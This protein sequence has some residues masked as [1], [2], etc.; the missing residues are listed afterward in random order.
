MA[1]L[2]KI[3][4]VLHEYEY[5]FTNSDG[6]EKYLTSSS[7]KNITLV[8]NIF[9]PFMRGSVSVANPFELFE[10][11]FQ[12]RG[13]GRD[14]FRMT[15]KTL[16]GNPSRGG[17]DSIE[18]SE[19]FIL[20]KE[21]NTG[22]MDVRSENIKSFKIISDDYLPFMDTIPYGRKYQGKV[23]DIIRDIFIELL[24]E[25]RID[26]ER[27][28]SGDFE[29]E[30][31]PPSS[32]RYVD[33]IYHLLKFFYGKDGELYVKAIIQRDSITR[34]YSM[35][36]ISRLFV[37]NSQLV[38]DVFTCADLFNE[39]AGA[40]NS[41]NPNLSDS[42]SVL[43]YSSGIKNF[44]Y[45]TPLYEWNNDF[46]INYIVHGYDPSLGVHSMRILRL[47]DIEPKWV[48]KFVN[49]FPTL[50][51]RP[52]PF[53]VKNN[54]TARKFRQYRTPYTIEDNVKMVESEIYNILTFYNL[55]CTFSNM[56]FLTRTAGKFV[57][58]VKIG[59]VEIESDQKMFGRWFITQIKHVFT[60]DSYSNFFACCKTYVGPLN[61][62]NQ[63]V[64]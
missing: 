9:N 40:G 39:R 46:F 64:N 12:L 5:V 2:I 18:F 49:F 35:Q 1:N 31:I 30:Y 27:W 14:K 7:V 24:G 47:E 19:S 44:A 10:D 36:F 53:L 33:L 17:S 48:S 59:D 32:F 52:K 13:D 56:G 23:G 28:E 22:D 42:F 20:L 29:I 57:D 3:N 50:G 58:I 21:E 6:F 43:A 45:D 16:V 51:G 11:G 4:D 8:D 15:L 54:N 61:K 34:R 55:N 62:I 37:T 25:K 38:A 41:N 26:F 63:N 60:N